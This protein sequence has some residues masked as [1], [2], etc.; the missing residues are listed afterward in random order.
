M[1]MNQN[2]ARNN[3]FVII[4]RPCNWSTS[5]I[6]LCFWLYFTSQSI[7]LLNYSTLV[8]KFEHSRICTLFILK[9]TSSPVVG[10]GAGNLLLV[11]VILTPAR[12]WGSAVN[13]HLSLMSARNEPSHGWY[14]DAACE[15]WWWAGQGEGCRWSRLGHRFQSCTLPSAMSVDQHWE[16]IAHASCVDR[17]PGFYTFSQHLLMYILEVAN[18]PSLPNPNIS[19]G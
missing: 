1:I 5:V 15:G 7:D 17:P 19:L 3:R 18:S 14:G 11:S 12:C 16:L 2:L 6:T 9:W 8:F 4:I 10:W 13:S